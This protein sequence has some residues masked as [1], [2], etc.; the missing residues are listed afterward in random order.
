MN[1]KATTVFLVCCAMLTTVLLGHSFAQGSSQANEPTK[2]V[3]HRLFE[4]ISSNAAQ[5]FLY[6]KKCNE[7]LIQLMAFSSDKVSS[8]FIASKMAWVEGR[9]TEAIAILENVIKNNGESISFQFGLPVAVLGNFWIGAIS[10][11]FGDVTLA[12]KAYA[13]IGKQ[14]ASNPKIGSLVVLSYLYQAE[15]E[16]QTLGQKSVAIESLKKIKEIKPPADQNSGYAIYQEWADYQM[17][18]LTKGVQDAR[19]SLKG[20]ARKREQCIMLVMSQLGVNGICGEPR[21][22][23]YNDERRAIL[24]KSLDMAIECRTS[25]ID[26]SLAQFLL[27]RISEEKGDTAKAEKYYGDLLAGDSYLAP[28]GGVNLACFQKKQ[29]KKEE[30]RKT[31]GKVKE[32]FPGYSKLVEDL[33]ER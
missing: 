1:Q 8:A 4:A 18:V 14:I 3:D 30:S 31:F 26:R 15:M 9:P 25:P 33:S 29:G 28:E 20:S 7:N 23:F 19:L 17:A 32:R 21:V 12:Q 16:Y 6:M 24:E 13:D 11:H 27:A 10:R 22:G 5:A 2:V